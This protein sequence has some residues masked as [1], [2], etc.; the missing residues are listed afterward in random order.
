MR[1]SSKRSKTCGAPGFHVG[2]L[3]RSVLLDSLRKTTR[4]DFSSWCFTETVSRFFSSFRSD[5]WPGHAHPPPPSQVLGQLS[6]CTPSPAPAEGAGS[7]ANRH[8][9]RPAHFFIGAF[10][11]KRAVCLLEATGG[12]HPFQLEEDP[13]LVRSSVAKGNKRKAKAV[14]SFE[15]PACFFRKA[16]LCTSPTSQSALVVRKSN[17]WHFKAFQRIG[18]WIVSDVGCF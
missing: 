9:L 6:H 18:R 8:R 3:F 12:K 5:T 17:N 1:K 13:E 15:V 4:V 16:K 2:N 11:Q 10:C 7:E 14:W